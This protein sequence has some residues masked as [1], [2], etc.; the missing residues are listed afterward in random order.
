M[1]PI[2]YSLEAMYAAHSLPYDITFFTSSTCV[3]FCRI[4]TR[5]TIVRC[6]VQTHLFTP[7]H[8]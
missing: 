4:H 8:I 5:F 2:A 1:F 6:Y 3:T 7:T